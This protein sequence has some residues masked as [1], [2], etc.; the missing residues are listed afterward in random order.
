MEIL[1]TLTNHLPTLVDDF[2]ARMKPLTDEYGTVGSSDMRQT[3]HDSLSYLILTLADRPLPERLIDMPSRL[4]VR[5]A[6]Q[7]VERDRLLEAV[8]LDYRVLWS[9]LITVAGTT[10]SAVIVQHAEDVLST[11]EEYIAEAQTAF[12]DELE[13]LHSDSHMR[14]TRA[15]AQLLSSAHP[16]ELAPDVAHTLRFPHAE[17]FEIALVPADWADAARA[18]AHGLAHTKHRFFVWNYD[19]AVLFVRPHTEGTHP[20]TGISG[21]LI[22]DIDGLAEVPRAA[23]R[24]HRLL[25]HRA[26][27]AL[28]A[29]ADL[30]FALTASTMAPTLP[31]FA[32][33]ALQGLNDLRDDDRDRVVET[34]LQYSTTGSLKRCA[35]DSFIHRNTVV[36]RLNT[37]HRATGL[38][39][40]IPQDAARAL[41][42]LSDRSAGQVSDP[43][44]Q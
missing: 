35:E 33:S 10:D 20:L 3:A 37:F 34:F 28:S 15:F 4:G 5:R 29:E 6:R 31:G 9:G 27:R 16:A 24:A 41:I 25:P 13:T 11:V 30:W 22:D 17:T 18:A 38:D 44:P 39:P 43:T 19:D 12:L 40:T 1:D 21:V 7:G 32:R 14:E 36:N 42:I 8:R 2:L 23:H 26:S